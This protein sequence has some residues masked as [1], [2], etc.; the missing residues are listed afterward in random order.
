MVFR[1]SSFYPDTGKEQTLE[2]DMISFRA[3]HMWACWLLNPLLG[4][5]GQRFNHPLREST[6][7]A[8]GLLRLSPFY[9]CKCLAIPKVRSGVINGPF[10]TPRRSNVWIVLD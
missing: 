4:K 2:E 1:F 3:S 10:T 9:D 8:L 5:P 7:I 6:E